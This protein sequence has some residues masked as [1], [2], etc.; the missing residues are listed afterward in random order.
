[1]R[2]KSEVVVLYRYASRVRVSLFLTV[3][4]ITVTFG[5]EGRLPERVILVAV[6]LLATVVD[7]DKV[8]IL[9]SVGRD[10]PL[11][12]TVIALVVA[13]GVVTLVKGT[14][15]LSPTYS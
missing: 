2:A 4:D 14:A 10:A 6:G 9:L 3:Y 13:G 15:I 5:N 7:C 1:M 12:V 11:F 8:D